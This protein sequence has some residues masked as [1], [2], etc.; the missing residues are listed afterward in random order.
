LLDEAANL[1][2]IAARHHDVEQH[3]RGPHLLEERERL[4]AVVRDGDRVPT[5]LQVLPDDLGVVLI[6][7]DHQDRW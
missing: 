6:I 1:P 7:V 3:E 5:D 4:V 2:A